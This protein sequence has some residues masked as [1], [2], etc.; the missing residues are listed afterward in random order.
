R[1][2]QLTYSGGDGNDVQLVVQNIAPTLS[3]L[4]TLNGGSLSYVEDSGAL[5][6]DSG[7]DALV[8]DA[9][10]S[11]FDGGNV[12]VSITSNGVSSEDA[13][14]VRNQ[15]TGSGQISL[16]GTSIRYE[17]TLIGTL[18]GGTAGNP[19]VI[20]LN[21]N[22][23]AAAVQA[24]VRNLT[25]TNTNSADMDTGSRTLSV[26]VS[27]GDGGTSSASTIAID[28][29]AVNDAPVLTVTAANPTYVENGSAVTLFTGATA[30]TVESGQTFTDLTL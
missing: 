16:S 11:D 17:G 3:D 9:D 14:S 19:L 26:S 28:F 20:S 27:D 25:Y 29:T 8:S 7:E 18:S 5:L 30:S 15:G 13:L 12:T 2:F 10:S 21:S 1:A 23:T 24:L 6:L 22:A 4:S